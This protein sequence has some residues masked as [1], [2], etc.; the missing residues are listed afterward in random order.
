MFVTVVD[1]SEI[2]VRTKVNRPSPILKELGILEKE[3]SSNLPR[4]I[5]KSLPK[6][7]DDNKG[8]LM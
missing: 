2:L 8:T 1:D 5:V 7:N 4:I 3:L 6:E